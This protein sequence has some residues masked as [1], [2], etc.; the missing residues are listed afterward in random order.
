MKK[1]ERNQKG[2]TLIALVLT[3]IVLLI[4]AG[5]T[6]SLIRDEEGILKRAEN[7][8]V[9]AQIA[10]IE[11]E[12][13]LI[14][15]DLLMGKYFDEPE[16]KVIGLADIVGQLGDKYTIKQIALEG[17]TVSGICVAKN[18]YLAPGESQVLDVLYE[19][20]SN[21]NEYYAVVNGQNYKIMLEKDGVIIARKATQLEKMEGLT[22]I[23]SNPN[24]TIEKIEGNQITIKA[25]MEAESATITV[26]YGE[27]EETCEVTVQVKPNEVVDES[28]EF[29]TAYGRIDV[30][31]LSENNSVLETPN[32]PDYYNNALTPVSWTK[33]G[34][35]WT[36]DETVQMPS[37]HYQEGIGT[38][39]NLS[40]LWANAK[41]GDGSYFVWI[42]RYAYRITYY[43]S[44][45][46]STPTGYYDGYGQWDVITKK[47]KHELDEGIET[48]EYQGKNYIVHPAFMK[49]MEK[50]GKAGE[51]LEDFARGGWNKNLSGFWVAKYEMSGNGATEESLGDGIL[52]FRSVPGVQTARGG[53]IGLI[54]TCSKNYDEAKKSHLMKNSEWGAVAYLAHSQ[55]GRNGHEVAINNNLI[56]G[57]GIGETAGVINAY[58]TKIGTKA[59]TTGNVYGVYDLSG[60]VVEAMSAF[61]DVNYKNFFGISNWTSATGLTIESNSTEYATKYMNQGDGTKVF[62]GSKIGDGIKEVYDSSQS[63]SW[64]QNYGLIPYWEWPFSWR[65]GDYSMSENAGIFTSGYYSGEVGANI[66]FRVVLAQ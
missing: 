36:E 44:E 30:I 41:N 6:L 65:G 21:S 38:E 7:A 26:R 39:D 22:A 19:G 28:L 9:Q 46:S 4:L 29:S 24:V 49:D 52:K 3:I 61:G 47:K 62:L 60:G 16:N 53:E 42:P 50:V 8:D 54:Y 48:V 15:A 25:G 43:E 34:E 59:S 12:A 32:A 56:T 63:C 5:V 51:P 20:I 13:N 27:F 57:N 37:Y 55:Y 45:K 64:F 18:L 23:S 10:N 11:E 58:N 40:S 66:G 1:W 33:N 14:Y 17:D 31:W 2:I 35:D